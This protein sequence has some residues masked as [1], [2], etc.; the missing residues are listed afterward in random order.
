[1][2]VSTHVC[3]Q[4][5]DSKRGYQTHQHI[6]QANCATLVSRTAPCKV[7]DK[8]MIILPVLKIDKDTQSEMMLDLRLHTQSRAS[9]TK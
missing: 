4:D 9:R 2:L 6:I 3:V 1:M 5:R 8:N 7:L